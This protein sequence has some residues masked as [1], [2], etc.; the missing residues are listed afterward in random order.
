MNA[1]LLAEIFA[2]FHDSCLWERKKTQLVGVGVE[3]CVVHPAHVRLGIKE[4]A[5]Q[6]DCA[7]MLYGFGKLRVA[8]VAVRKYLHFLF[9]L[10]INLLAPFFAGFQ[11]RSQLPNG[12]RGLVGL[13]ERYV[14]SRN[15]GPILSQYLN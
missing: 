15:F 1:V 6:N 8:I 12:R 11:L 10:R 2:P 9:Q 7:R 4:I 14:K 5:A 3:R 13:A